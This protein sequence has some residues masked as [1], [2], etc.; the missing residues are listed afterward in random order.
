MKIYALNAS[1]RKGWNCEQVLDSFIN[2]V[3]DENPEIE[4]ERI[5]IYDLD[6]KG[7]RSCFACQMKH[8]ENGHCLFHDGAYELIRGIKSG[9]GLVFASP[10]YYFDLPSQMR[11]ILE[12]LFY[13]GAADHE[14]PVTTI[15]TMNQKQENAEKYFKKHLDDI[16]FFFRNE[17]HTEPEELYVYNTLHWKNPEKYNFPMEWYED[18]YANRQ[19]NFAHDLQCAFET[20]KRFAHKLSKV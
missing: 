19:S 18:K 20:G 16:A 4:I 14:I 1:P 15:Y 3:T 11:A 17:F 13:P 12:R 7:C 10:I 6:F 9:D 2:G 8:T 5:N